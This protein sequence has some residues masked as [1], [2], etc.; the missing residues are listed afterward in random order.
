VR[1]PVRDVSVRSTGV[2]AL[3]CER[4]EERSVGGAA[5]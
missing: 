3:E 5:S 4:W 2:C 1:L